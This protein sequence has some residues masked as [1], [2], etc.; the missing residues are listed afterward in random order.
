MLTGPIESWCITSNSIRDTL[1]DAVSRHHTQRKYYRGDKRPPKR[2]RLDLNQLHLKMGPK[3]N[4]SKGN[5]SSS[6]EAATAMDAALASLQ[7]LRD[8]ARNWDVDVA[9]W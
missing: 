7:P 2:S 8:L 1:I 4:S 6:S 9:S 3:R 5:G